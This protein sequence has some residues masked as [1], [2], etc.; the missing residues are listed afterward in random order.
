M[1]LYFDFPWSHL[2]ATNTWTSF[3]V[4]MGCCSECV[5][6]LHFV[7]L[8]PFL[9][10]EILEEVE[11]EDKFFHKTTHT[12]SADQVC[13]NSTCCE[14]EMDY[15]MRTFV[16]T[17]SAKKWTL[18]AAT[19]ANT[20]L[21]MLKKSHILLNWDK[22]DLRKWTER[23]VNW[24]YQTKRRQSVIILGVTSTFPVIIAKD[25]SF[26]SWSAGPLHCTKSWRLA[27]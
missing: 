18:L 14:W 7:W 9:I 6:Y 5:L 20:L 26:V 23:M 27:A 24:S 12:F 11:I 13:A 10:G 16:N 22:V 17:W 8:L 1:W 25:L 4:E 3:K 19:T 21:P 2:C 15:R